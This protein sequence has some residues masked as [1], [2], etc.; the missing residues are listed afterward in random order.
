MKFKIDRPINGSYTLK[1]THEETDDFSWVKKYGERTI[2]KERLDFIRIDDQVIKGWIDDDGVGH[3]T[4]IETNEIIEVNT[5]EE[6][7]AITKENEGKI[8]FSTN[9]WRKDLDGWIEI[10]DDYRE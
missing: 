10:Y 7:Y 4:R 6:L 8:V 1:I 2:E 5:L 3:R 9:R